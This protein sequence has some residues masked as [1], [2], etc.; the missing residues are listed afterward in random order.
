MP[1]P[2]AAAVAVKRRNARYRGRWTLWDESKL[3]RVRSCGR[4]CRDANGVGVMLAPRPG[5]GMV[6]GFSG[7]ASCGS[8][9]ACPVCSAKIA[10]KR[11]G[12]LARAVQAWQR[13]GGRIAML[14][15]TV[16]H[17]KS[18]DL[19]HLWP[20]IS[21]AWHATTSGAA[22]TQEQTM[23]GVDLARVVHSGKRKG[24]T[25]IAKRIRTVRLVE[26]TYGENGWHI[27]IHAILFLRP[28]VNPLDAAYLGDEMFMRWRDSVT[29]AG[30]PAPSWAHGV[31]CHLVGGDQVGKDISEY[32]VKATYD[33]RHIPS[34]SP[35]SIKA[36]VIS[37]A[38]SFETARTDLKSAQRDN[39]Q[40]FQILEDI[41]ERGDAADLDIWHEWEA[42]SKG[43]RQVAWSQG[44]RAELLEGEVEQSDEEIAEE[45]IADGVEVARIPGRSWTMVAKAH[46]DALVLLAFETDVTAGLHLLALY[47]PPERAQ[48]PRSRFART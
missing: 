3:A 17:N 2:D 43:R 33:G 47:R 32:F 13:Q 31:D 18:H 41:V 24:E 29:G 26:V 28:G 36:G 20:I 4:T 35:M 16:R 44:L 42:G 22:W 39:R 34:A 40:P 14:T 25:V 45:V 21:D 30:M 6:A 46:A 11:Q 15:L 10:A 37:R 5:G 27:H 8:V 1:T 9:W 12:E 23:F 48:L 7:L 19:A 38:V